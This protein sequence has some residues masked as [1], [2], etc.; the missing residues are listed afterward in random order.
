LYALY[1]DGTDQN[2]DGKGD[3]T[4]ICIDDPNSS[5][6]ATDLSQ[7][8]RDLGAIPTNTSVHAGATATVPFNL[9]YAGAAGSG[10]FTVAASTSV[11]SATAT[12]SITTLTPAADSNNNMTVS[13][14]VPAAT[15]PNTYTVTVTATCSGC[16]ARTGVATLTVGK[17]F[18]FDPAPALPALGTI[19]LNGQ[20]QNKTA[21]MN[22]FGVNDTTASPSGWNVTVT[23]DSSAGKSPVFKQYCNN[24]GSAC[25]SDPANSYVSGGRTLA[26]SSLTLNS[27]GASWTG[28]TGS[29]PTFQCGGGSCAIDSASATKIGSAANG[30]AG[31]GLWTTNGFSA[32]S[33]KLSTPSTLRV[34]PANEIYRLDI[35]WSLN[36]GP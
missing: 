4:G 2:S 11:P 22:N 30:S 26:A 31:T 16:A 15:T 25:G 7:T 17:N 12:P 9:K 28:G 13:V 20:A 35:V 8:T 29:A 36:S 14:P 1:N 33:V 19:A 32:S 21:Q 23:G 3:Q 24:G 27:T 10:A 5:T 18:D 34:L 6:V